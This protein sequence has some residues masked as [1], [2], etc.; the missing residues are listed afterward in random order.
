MKFLTVNAF[1]TFILFS[2]MS[3]SYN[4]ISLPFCLLSFI[5]ALT[6]YTAFSSIRGQF[7]CS[8]GHFLK[9][10]RVCLP[11]DSRFPFSCPGDVVSQDFSGKN[12]HFL[13]GYELDV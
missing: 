1:H 2:I 7:L 3:L 6:S 13:E 8:K 4:F 10:K 11:K 12:R 5:I 9:V